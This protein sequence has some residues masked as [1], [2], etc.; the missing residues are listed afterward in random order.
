ME[1]I[2]DDGERNHRN[3]GNSEELKK[4]RAKSLERVK[5][6]THRNAGELKKNFLTDGRD[7]RL[8][9]KR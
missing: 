1:R 9:E 2:T 7:H 4:R 3:S 8:K 6:G 5:S